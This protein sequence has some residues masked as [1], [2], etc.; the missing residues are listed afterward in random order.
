[1]MYDYF[2][3]INRLVVSR[4]EANPTNRVAE[5]TFPQGVTS[6]AYRDLYGS[7]LIFRRYDESRFRERRP[8]TW[9]YLKMR[10]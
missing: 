2:A 5:M 10:Y 7:V 9:E 6:D 8:H 4:Y 3:A 1:M